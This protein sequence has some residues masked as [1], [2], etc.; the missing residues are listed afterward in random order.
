MRA[1]WA[2]SAGAELGEV[3]AIGLHVGVV[4]VA[5]GLAFEARVE[6]LVEGGGEALVVSDHLVDR[7][8]EAAAQPLC[9]SERGVELCRAAQDVLVGERLSQLR[10]ALALGPGGG[11]EVAGALREL[12]R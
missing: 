11:Q 5:V 12:Y 8:A 3:R 1:A 7:E 2:C 9:E 4:P 6:L 10:Q